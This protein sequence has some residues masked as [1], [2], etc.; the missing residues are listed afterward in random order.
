MPR[1]RVI[2]IAIVAVVAVGIGGFIVYDQVLRGDSAAALTLPT[3]SPAGQAPAASADAGA[4][5]SAAPAT[6]DGRE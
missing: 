6:A 1:S 3:A 5:S 4:N 2:A